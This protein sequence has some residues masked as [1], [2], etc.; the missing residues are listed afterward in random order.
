[1]SALLAWGTQSLEEHHD[2][3]RT[4]PVA[5]RAECGTALR[6]RGAP[7]GG[8]GHCALDQNPTLSPFIRARKTTLI[9]NASDGTI[10]E[11]NQSD[12]AHVH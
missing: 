6:V 8:M 3:L 1:M 11:E 9:P 5:F 4:F 10:R 2:E 12:T 7:L